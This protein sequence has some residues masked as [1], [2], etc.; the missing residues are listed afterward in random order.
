MTQK[1]EEPRTCVYICSQNVCHR[2]GSNALGTAETVATLSTFTQTGV[3]PTIPQ[4]GAKQPHVADAKVE[5]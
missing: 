1:T 5:Q 2:G 3:L 4:P